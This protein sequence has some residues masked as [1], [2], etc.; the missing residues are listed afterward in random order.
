MKRSTV[1]C[2]YNAVNFLANPHNIHPFRARYGVSFVSTHSDIWNA[3]V[4]AVLY[5]LSCYT[6]L[7]YNGTRLYMHRVLVLPAVTGS[8]Q[9]VF[10]L[11][12]SLEWEQNWQRLKRKMRECWQLIRKQHKNIDIVITVCKTSWKFKQP[13]GHIK[14]VWC[15]NWFQGVEL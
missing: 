11:T 14:R 8:L 7:R 1:R 2:C 3:W 6:G 15:W 10:Y 13:C 5:E 12:A 4:N 9:Q